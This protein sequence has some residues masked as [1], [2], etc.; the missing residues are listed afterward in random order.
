MGQASRLALDGGRPVARTR[1]GMWPEVT[2]TDRE[3]RNAVDDARPGEVD[4]PTGP[5]IQRLE[6]GF[7]AYCGVRNAVALGSGTDALVLG[8]QACG[9]AGRTNY[10]AALG[11]GTPTAA[12]AAGSVV[13]FADIDARSY[14]ISAEALRKIGPD[15]GAVGVT[16]LG[17]AMAQMD[18]I[19]EA[20]ATRA[21][22]AIVYEDACHAPGATYLGRKAGTFGAF[23]AFSLAPQKCFTGLGGGLL[24]TDDDALAEEVRRR[25]CHGEFRQ[26][27]R[28][29]QVNPH[30][31]HGPGR[32]SR[33]NP[34]AAALAWSQ[35][36]RLDEY[37]RVAQK[38]ART[39][40]EGLGQLP[41]FITP[42]LPEGSTSTEHLYRVGIDPSAFGWEGTDTE[43][44]DRF[45]HAFRSEGVPV[46]VYGLLAYCDMPFFA[47]SGDT[48]PVAVQTAARTLVFGRFPHP[49][50][51]QTPDVMDEWV[52]AAE[53]IVENIERVLTGPYKPLD[54]NPPLS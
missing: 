13:R 52:T 37:L 20:V 17:G 35:L 32:N 50:Q 44:R 28:P 16:H 47:S 8:M 26:P 38:N 7:A 6:E 34:Y 5:F 33:P 1:L 54:I 46:G 42:Y 39:L 18:V 4:S 25:A 22:G 23:G 27:L 41:G 3:V 49:L 2:E 36:R 14:N 10:V 51:V 29:G 43:L 12:A 53:K 9:L 21:P 45:I 11:F 19:M 31:V 15:T 24:I 40:T 48:A 30:T